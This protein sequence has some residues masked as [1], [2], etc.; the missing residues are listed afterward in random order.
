MSY[1]I[2]GIAQI[3]GLT[4]WR[5][6]EGERCREGGRGVDVI[7]GGGGGR[8]KNWPASKVRSQCPIALLIEVYIWKRVKCWEVRKV[9]GLGS[10]FCYEH[11]IQNSM[12]W[13]IRP[14]SSIKVNRRFG[15]T[16]RCLSSGLKDN[17]SKKPAWSRQQAELFAKLLLTALHI[18]VDACFTLGLF[19]NMPPPASWQISN[20]Y[21]VSVFLNISG[22]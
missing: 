13:D 12:F 8:R 20:R 1:S 10:R 16:C 3:F 5:T 11:R 21:S 17:P 7:S 22:T 19:L 14:C 4:L 6:R 9:K 18:H 2:Q 15:E